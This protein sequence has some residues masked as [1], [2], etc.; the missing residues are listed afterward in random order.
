M[1][2][3]DDA[4]R[5]QLATAGQMKTLADLAAKAEHLI[6]ELREKT[7]RP[8]DCHVCGKRTKEDEQ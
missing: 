7:R 3:S 2:N 6:T 1:A 4:A 8:H 5:A